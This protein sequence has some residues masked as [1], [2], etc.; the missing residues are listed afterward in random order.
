MKDLSS[1]ED[2][3]PFESSVLE[4][5][6]Q[7]YTRGGGDCQMLNR[8]R[9]LLEESI[10]G[11]PATCLI[12][13]ASIK[14]VDAIWACE[15][16]FSYFHLSCI[17]KWSNDS[18]SLC[19]M[20]PNTPVIVVAFKRIEWCCPKCRFAYSKEEIP[21]KYR[22]FCGKL[23]NPPLHPWLIPHSCGEVCGKRLSSQKSD[24]C[25]H[26][27]LLLCHPGPCPPC[28]QMVSRTCFC[29]S[30]A[31]K[32]RCSAQP[33]SCG[34]KC[35]RLLMCG[36][37]RCETTCHGD[38]CPPCNHTSTQP[39]LC[40]AEKTMRP[41]NQPVWQCKKICSKPFSCGHHK[42]LQVCHPGNCGDCPYSGL[43]SCPCG[44]TQ[45]FIECPDTMETC[46][47][48][49]NKTHDDC[50]HSCP[51]KCHKGPCPPCQILVEKKCYCTTHVKSVPCSKEFKCDTKCRGI[52]ACRKHNCGRKCCNGNC[53][54]CEKVCDKLLHCG[55]HRCTSV[56]HHGPCYPCPLE[57]K[58]SCRCKHTSVSVPCGREKH[59]KPPKC[60]QLCK[61]K[62]KCGHQSENAHKCHFSDCPACKAVCDK[63]YQC[64]H[65]CHAICHEYVAVT[66][67]QVEKPATPWEVQPPK[68]K[69]MTLECP[70][71]DTPVPITCFG[72]HETVNQLC[73]KALRYSCGRSCGQLLPC[74]NHTCAMMCHLFEKSS[75]FLTVPISCQPCDKDC[76]FPRPEKCIHAC[77]IGS[78]HPGRCPTCEVI[79]KLPCHC[80][81][82]EK[83]LKCYQLE[84]VTDEMLSC[85]LQCP[86]NMMCGHR[87]K[88]NCHAGECP[89]QQCTK[90]VKIYCPCGNV[91]KDTQCYTTKDFK[92]PC[93][94]TC[95]AKRL[96]AQEEKEREV[97][98]QRLLEEERNRKELAEYEWK[99]SGKKR[100]YKEKK[101]IIENDDRNFFVKYWISITSVLVILMAAFVFLLSQ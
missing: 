25:Q 89:E 78:C 55:Q 101:V 22:C 8:T 12:C 50:E 69:I 27:C 39:C 47:G 6:L 58:V 38:S 29:E 34:S 74:E 4:G 46:L 16:C 95:E 42:C 59:T 87:C 68:T 24:I 82:N 72:G 13:I 86:K 17:Q 97:Q 19:Q 48:T 94:E 37:H 100:K 41:C 11:R 33:W 15:H 53:P 9:N 81:L 49:C 44:A 52:R 21:R 60:T 88:S 85:E 75:E 36:S 5:V 56:C 76:Q 79:R 57:S 20:D 67:K 63:E 35:N 92:V 7:S 90:K 32:V 98:R 61:I 51:E 2:E 28:P 31:K 84:T 1:S 62:Y 10:S 65:K 40:G 99:M 26:K 30:D 73:H 96:A 70:P 54:A 64:G 83:Y 3:E 14:R 43:K 23:N 93:D 80:G 91:K 18:I 71:C 77:P 66:F 45:K